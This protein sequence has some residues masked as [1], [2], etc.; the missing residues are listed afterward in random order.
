MRTLKK[1]KLVYNLLS[2][3]R[4]ALLDDVDH[5]QISVIVYAKCTMKCLR[6]LKQTIYNHDFDIDTLQTCLEC[7][8]KS[9]MERF[10]KY[11]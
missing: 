11:S 4:L 3:M 8:Q 2:T 10:C 9:M 7:C 5:L 6:T 1:N